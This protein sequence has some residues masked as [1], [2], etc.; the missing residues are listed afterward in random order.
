MTIPTA[1]RRTIARGIKTRYT[2]D[3]RLAR[4]NQTKIMKLTKAARA[5]KL[6]D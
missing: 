2:Q 6:A 3:K 5:A 1:T 4:A